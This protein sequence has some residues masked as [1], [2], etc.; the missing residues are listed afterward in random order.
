V[1]PHFYDNDL[2]F[3]IHLTMRLVLLVSKKRELLDANERRY[4][5]C[6]AG[7]EVRPASPGL[8]QPPSLGQAKKK[9]F[10]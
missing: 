8:E 1:S 6:R 4:V 5:L 10:L 2:G 7:F 3:V 9:I